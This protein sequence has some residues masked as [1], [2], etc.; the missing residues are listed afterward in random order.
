[1][2]LV[3]ITLRLD[4]DSET[5]HRVTNDVTSESS[6]ALGTV[7]QLSS[8]PPRKDSTGISGPLLPAP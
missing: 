5:E 4:D 8:G 1:M 7:M 2:A 6:T 3:T